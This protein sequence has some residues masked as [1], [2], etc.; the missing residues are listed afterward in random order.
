M[1]R[2]YLNVDVGFGLLT[3]YENIEKR[4]KFDFSF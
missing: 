4:S 3:A 2:C 1:Y